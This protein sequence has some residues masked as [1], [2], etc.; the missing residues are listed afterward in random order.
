[1]MDMSAANTTLSYAGFYGT[2]FE[3]FVDIALALGFGAVQLIPDQTPN[4]LSELG[5]ARV[6]GLRDKIASNKLGVSV[7]AI[8]YDVNVVSVVPEVRS[9][10]LSIV[11]SCAAFCDALG[12]RAVTVH[13]GYMFPGWRS[14][15]SQAEVFWRSA[16]LG[17]T[18][19]DE[20]SHKYRSNLFIENGSYFVSDR[21]MNKIIPLHVGITIDEL[22][23]LLEGLSN[24]VGLC[25]DIGK[26]LVSGMDIH[27][28]VDR[29]P[30]RIG[31]LQIGSAASIDI[32]RRL[33][34][35]STPEIV[36]EGGRDA[37]VAYAAALP[38]P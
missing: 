2:P 29:I 5:Q 12:G 11:D 32:V 25:L 23:A 13:P 21:S 19:L 10:A 9:A 7:H 4:L 27:Q 15:P 37:A 1:M 16:K 24:S 8:F 26:A 33:Q 34:F 3:E 35:M 31:Q 20:I 28:L 6:K 38:G 14:S 17:M 30:E 18:G 36:F 22:E